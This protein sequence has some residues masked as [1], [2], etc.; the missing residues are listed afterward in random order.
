M[1]G[2]STKNDSI[3]TVTDDDIRISNLNITDIK[4]FKS[5]SVCIYI[6]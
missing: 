3:V 2:V 1:M 6:R 5:K 4:I